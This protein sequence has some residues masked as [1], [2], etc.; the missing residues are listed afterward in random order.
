VAG[1]RAIATNLPWEIDADALERNLG[2]PSI[3]LL[4]DLEATAHGLAA[5]GDD[6]FVELRAGAPGATGNAALVA[7]GTGLGEAAMFWDGRRHRPFACEGGHTDFAPSDDREAQLLAW[8]RAKD[9]LG[10]HVSWERVVSGQGLV[11]LFEFLV[12]ESGQVVPDE[13]ADA[14]AAGDRPA[15]IT[16]WGRS[17]RDPTCREALDWFME[18]YG[19]EAGNAALKFL[20]TGGLYLAGG[21]APK[22][23]DE[24][25]KSKFVE[26]F[27]DKGRM[28]R[29]VEKIPIRIVLDDQAAIRGAALAA[30]HRA[31]IRM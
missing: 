17:D 12:D 23:A 2:I 25:P 3:F 21:I 26:R 16:E 1:R 15:V 9:D 20:A 29:I 24:L 5:L 10:G 4:N 6:D 11:N 28:R 30:A 14:L 8:L 13:L 18:L 22:L 27:D 7:A 31:S 19:A